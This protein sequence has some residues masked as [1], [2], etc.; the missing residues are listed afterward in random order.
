MSFATCIEWRSIKYTDGDYGFLGIFHSRRKQVCQ[1]DV[2][3]D[4]KNA[5]KLTILEIQTVPEFQNQGYA[6]LMMRSLLQEYGHDYD[7]YLYARPFNASP[8]SKQQ[9]VAWYE[10]FGFHSSNNGK[11]A[12]LSRK[13]Q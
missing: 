12:A 1:V 4:P 3:I 9:L 11:P 2:M 5:E 6:T 8:L 10:K 13:R 7:I